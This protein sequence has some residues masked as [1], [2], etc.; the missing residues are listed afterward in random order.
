MIE[1]AFWITR[2]ICHAYPAQRKQN[3][4]SDQSKSEASSGLGSVFDIIFNSNKE[5]NAKNDNKTVQRH[6]SV[7]T[8]PTQSM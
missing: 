8:C 6:D 3:S 1:I 7:E 4:E 5:A 2:I